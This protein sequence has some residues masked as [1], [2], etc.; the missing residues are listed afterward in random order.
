VVSPDGVLLTADDDATGSLL[1]DL[2]WENRH[3][4]R[5]ALPDDEANTVIDTIPSLSGVAEP[6]L[7]R[8]IPVEGL[9]SH[10]LLFT[11]SG[12]RIHR[13]GSVDLIDRGAATVSELASFAITKSG[14]AY[15]WSLETSASSYSGTAADPID[16]I[17]ASVCES[18]VLIL[19]VF[20]LGCQG[21]RAI[22]HP[23]AQVV[24]NTCSTSAGA[25]AM[26]LDRLVCTPNLQECRDDFIVGFLNTR[27]P[28]HQIALD[29][30]NTAT[31]AS[32]PCTFEVLAGG[33]TQPSP[34]SLLNIY[35]WVNSYTGLYGVVYWGEYDIVWTRLYEIGGYEFWRVTGRFNTPSWWW[36]EQCA[37]TVYASSSMQWDDSRSV[38]LGSTGTRAYW[39][40]TAFSNP[41][42][43]QAD[44]ATLLH[45]LSTG[46]GLLSTS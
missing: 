15:A 4:H 9:S 2:G 40:G 38:A 33:P 44:T 41:D 16:E 35:T 6:D 37:E 32:A 11:L 12:T 19:E 1:A 39:T 43:L 21:I 22:P 3:D 46:G 20:A 7:V 5:V 8:V 26:G 42:C 18:W 45:L 25:S 36:Y 13:T 29:C 27:I 14:D 31:S 34:P 10:Y 23:A 24:A 17:C 28:Y 30:A